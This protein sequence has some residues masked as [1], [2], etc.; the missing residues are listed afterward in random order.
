MP[1][2]EC[3]QNLRLKNVKEKIA[4]KMGLLNYVRFDP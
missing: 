2:K 4:K 3:H 1:K